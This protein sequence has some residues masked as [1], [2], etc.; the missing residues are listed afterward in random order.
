MHMR[1]KTKVILS[2]T[3]VIVLLGSLIAR[4]KITMSAQPA[5]SSMN[6]T[7]SVAVAPVAKQ[8]LNERIPVIGTVSAFNDVTVLSE[9]QGRIVKVNVEVGDVVKAGTVLV[10]VDS[11]LKAAA[12][13]A[14][15]VSYEKA[16]K[17]LARYEALY[18][19]HSIP[20]AQ[21]EQAR[22]SYQ[23]AESQYIVARRQLSDTKITSPIAGIVTARPVNFGTM[24]MGAPQA[25]QIAN[26]VDLSRLKAKVNIAEQDVFK[27]RKGDA[28]EVTSDVF[29]AVT[30]T[31]TIFSISSKCD[32][33]HTYP[34]EVVVVDPH[35][36]LKAGMFV[37]VTFH[38]A[39]ATP[40]LLVPRMAIVGSMQ[41]PK[42]YVVSD[43]VATLRP[44]VAVKQIGTQVALSSG[45]HE[46][47]TVVVDGQNNLSDSL[48]VLVRK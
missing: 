20:D 23:S 2:T 13:K 1:T 28:V 40:L 22:W 29:P 3:V 26:V 43:N 25:T 41:E 31:G 36:Q 9:T 48:H 10:E 34:V 32:D 4:N 11:E 38:P 30:F 7:P 37:R 24:V 21:I 16:K 5:G 19:E 6:T 47:E 8:T 39:E 12:F 17:D 35:H 15:E 27:L 33:A 42:V 46:G 18:K 14:A 44:V 45:V